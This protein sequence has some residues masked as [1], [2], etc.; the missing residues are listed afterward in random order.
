M[1]EPAKRIQHA[2]GGG[3]RRGSGGSRSTVPPVTLTRDEIHAMM[4]AAETLRDRTIIQ[5]LFSTACR[6]SEAALMVW[7]VTDTDSGT[8]GWQEAAARFRF[9][10]PKQRKV[11][12]VPLGPI[13]AQALRMWRQHERV[14]L[15][16]VHLDPLQPLFLSRKGGA[17]SRSAV[18]RVVKKC[19]LAAGIPPGKARPHVIRH[20]TATIMRNDGAQLDEIQA[21]LGHASITSTQVY[22]HVALEHVAAACARAG[23]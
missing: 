13:G 7:G 1:G 2:T 22:D 17:M 20:S 11:H 3:G 12:E 15:K 16:V 5:T 18:F 23:L 8:L 9:Y 21:L 19:G 14:R 6:V 10:R 4:R